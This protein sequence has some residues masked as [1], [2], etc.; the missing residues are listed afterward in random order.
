MHFEIAKRKTTLCNVQE[1]VNELL[2]G[3]AAIEQTIQAL[4]TLQEHSKPAVL[5][6]DAL[7]DI[8]VLEQRLERIEVIVRPLI[9]QALLQSEQIDAFLDKYERMMCAMDAATKGL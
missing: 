9:D 8:P 7:H 5:N 1:R 3:R 6:F 2:A 4:Q